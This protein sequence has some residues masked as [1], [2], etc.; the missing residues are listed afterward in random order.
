[1]LP[2][3]KKIVSENNLKENVWFIAK[4]PIETLRKYT[5]ASS[6]GV[7]LDKDNNINYKFSLPNKIF[8]YIH[9]GIPVLA[10]DL[11]E[12]SKIIN[13]YKIGKICP[14]HNPKTIANCIDEMIKSEEKM[15][16]WEANTTIAAK[17]FNWDKEKEKLLAIFKK[18][19]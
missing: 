12:I 2:A 1:V 19:G 17:D 18:I 4:Q 11:P 10:S 8:D 5:A 6:I 7:T 13:E 3:L 14:D 9:A 15:K 16:E